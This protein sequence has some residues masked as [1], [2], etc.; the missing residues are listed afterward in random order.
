MHM[1]A[2]D[3]AP[4]A[5]LRVKLLGGF[6]VER[7]DM[8]MPI[9]QW[10]RRSAKTLTKLLATAPGHALHREQV[11]EV[12]WPGSNLDSALNSFG[13]T[14]HAARRAF[15]PG[16]PPRQ[17]SPYLLMVDSMVALGDGFVVVDADQFE[18][19]ALRALRRSEISALESALAAYAGE[20][21]P[22]DRYAD[23]CT[24]R[25]EFLADLRIR[26]L[27]D[28]SDLLEAH[29]ALNESADRLRTVLQHDPT[30]E[31]VH[32]RLMRLYTEMGT[33]DQ[34]VRQFHVCEHVLQRE[35]DFAPHAET[36]AV[37]HDILANRMQER[38]VPTAAP[39]PPLRTA[40]PPSPLRTV[41]PPPLRTAPP[42]PPR[43]GAPARSA[44]A[45]QPGL[46]DPFVGRG[47]I[48][49]E[50]CRQLAPPSD[51]GGMVV[52]SGEAG[53]G[54]SRLLEEVAK[55]AAAEDAVVLRGGA[56]AHG[57]HF[58]CGPFA[59]AL[60]GYVAARSHA[61]RRE[62]ARRY[63]PLLGFVPS[64]VS[65]TRAPRVPGV[66]GD[67]LDVM[68]AIARLLSDIADDHPV[69]LVLGDLRE[70]DPDSI[71]MVGYLAR[72][73][74]DRP[75]LLLGA[76]REE[77]LEPGTAVTRLLAT[78]T[79]EGL[80]RNVELHCLSRA[81]CH[82]LVAAMLP[83][84]SDRPELLDQIYELSRGNPMFVRELVADVRAQGRWDERHDG[85]GSSRPL[86]ARVPNRVRALAETRLASLDS[87]AQRVL[88]L[89]A[90]SGTNE[91]SLANLRT[92]AAALDPPV[93]DGALLDAL[94][95]A[96]ETRLLEEHTN[97]YAFRHPLVRSAFYERLSRGRRAQLGD[98][99]QH[100][101]AAS[102]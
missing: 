4:V 24:E 56:G 42:S 60:E 27:L 70:A 20:L 22:E 81:Q 43:N 64:L 44:A 26:L 83:S 75:W 102:S 45:D 59:V 37:Y 71:D 72:L 76:V 12:L 65:E 79:R 23:W 101:S 67:H 8:A 94:D 10:Q 14:L 51:G 7:D 29:G 95:R 41:P 25:R 87:T 89:A 50:L 49:A 69:V 11:L 82:E 2:V 90:A 55:R 38:T 35:L 85:S 61:E 13:K 66:H 57:S 98:A 63:P 28:L 96:L 86:A 73:A 74:V 9:S 1:H 30:R 6:R 77:E 92:S 17:G 36:V 91:V 3:T 15:Q 93:G 31:D 99:L 80:C 18:A 68:P 5:Q 54:K 48:L 19:A 58:V 40:P 88:L 100:Y 52:V 21:L 33:P 84:A 78:A 53:I 39:A 47:A 32:R 34:A 46:H 16:L 97:G 62:L